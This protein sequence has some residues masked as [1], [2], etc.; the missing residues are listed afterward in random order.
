[1]YKLEGC[2]TICFLN[3]KNTPTFFNQNSHSFEISKSEK[4]K[5]KKKKEKKASGWRLSD[6]LSLA[7]FCQKIKIK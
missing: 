4:E 6:F 1:L 2:L 3:K 5:K 7:K